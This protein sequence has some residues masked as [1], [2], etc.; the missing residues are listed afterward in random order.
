MCLFNYRRQDILE[1]RT[2]RSTI[3]WRL[4]RLLLEED[5]KRR[6]RAANPEL[7]NGQLKSMIR[8]W[9]IEAKGTV[10]VSRTAV[11][12]ATAPAR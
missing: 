12:P 11:E 9:F 6:I 3:Y 7:R 8:R 5:I 10:N 2:S 1:W 4:Q